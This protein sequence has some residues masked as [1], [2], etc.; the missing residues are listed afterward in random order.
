MA[1]FNSIVE[2][3]KEY[4][5]SVEIE[6]DRVVFTPKDESP[7]KNHRKQDTYYMGIMY[8]HEKL[9]NAYAV[10]SKEYSDSLVEIKAKRAQVDM[11]RSVSKVR[12]ANFCLSVAVDGG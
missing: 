8:Q 4:D 12:A 9:W 3:A 7:A 10:L 5:V 1:T 2:E 6:P 11:R